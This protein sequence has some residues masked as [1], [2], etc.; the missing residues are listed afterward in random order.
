MVKDDWLANIS[1]SDRKINWTDDAVKQVAD[2]MIL[3]WQLVYVGAW[4]HGLVSL[5]C[6][7]PRFQDLVWTCVDWMGQC[8]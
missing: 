3:P 7:T 6:I 5:Q 1:K 4:F 2:H 8:Y